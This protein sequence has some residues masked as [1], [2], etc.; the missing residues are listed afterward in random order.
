MLG[1][2]FFLRWYRRW[3]VTL[4]RMSVILSLNIEDRDNEKNQ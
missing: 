2:V 4:G 1:Y 3:K